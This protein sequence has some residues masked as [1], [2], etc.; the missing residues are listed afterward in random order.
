M[1]QFLD[2]NFLLKTKTAEYLYHNHASKMP[3]YDYHCHI[4]PKEIYEDRKFESITDMWI[5]DGHAGDHYKWRALR[6]NGVGEKYITG[7]ATKKEKFLKWAETIPYLMGNP[8]YHWTHLEMKRFFGIE[9]L[10]SP[11]TADKIYDQ[12]NKTLET[13]TARK[14]IKMA[15]VKHIC[16]TDDPIDDLRYHILMRDDATFDVDVYPTF[17]P[18][19]IVNIDLNG[20]VAYVSKLGEVVGYEIKNLQDLEK[21]LSSRVDFFNSVGCRVADHA[22]DDVVFE[23]A[24]RESVDTIFRKTL[25]SETLTQK[26]IAQYKGYIVVFLGR[27]YHKYNWAQQYHIKALRNNNSRMM[28]LI[29]PDTGFDSINDGN[30][31]KALSAIMNSLDS[32]DQ[33]PK[34]ILYSLN[35]S[36]NEVLCTLAY[37]FQK[38]GI[39]AK[40]QLGSGWWFL[41]QKDGMQKQ[42]TALSHLGLF[43]RF[44]GMLTDSRSFLSYTRHEYFRRILCNFIGDLVENGEYPNDLEFLGKVVEDICYNNAKEYF[45]AGR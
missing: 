2:D 38:E 1:K 10:L 34:T 40:I 7:D 4:S 20:F 16:T 42:M 43:T 9:E 44:I 45:D 37:C 28:S 14:I 30:I 36:D 35:P 21:A 3:I 27:Q 6:G 8:L 29:G 26:E 17:R 18:D 41:D 19:K 33:L 13:M 32:T 22:L 31:A 11:K 23:K 15:N 12:M 5:V 39:K 24:S 25:A